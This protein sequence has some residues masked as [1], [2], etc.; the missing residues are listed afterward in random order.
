MDEFT[1]QTSHKINIIIQSFSHSTTAGDTS[2]TGTANIPE[3]LGLL[4]PF[5]GVC[6]TQ[7]L[8][9]SVELFFF[10]WQLCCRFLFV[11]R[12]LIAL[13]YL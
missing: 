11:L 10:I 5:S 7:S 9:L 6:G 3:H 8:A 1:R 4:P 13:W 2:R 12:L